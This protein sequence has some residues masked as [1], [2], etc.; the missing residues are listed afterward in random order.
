M[1]KTYPEIVDLAP[2]YIQF[3]FLHAQRR[4]ILKAEEKEDEF[5]FWIS[6]L[7]PDVYK[8][9]LRREE[10]EVLENSSYDEE[11]SEDNFKQLIAEAEKRKQQMQIVNTE[12][13]KP[14]TPIVEPKVENPVTELG[15]KAHPISFRIE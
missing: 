9:I 13:I 12:P 2:H 7:R 10:Q 8:E 5:K 3:H 1:H 14:R 4:Q 15:T 11:M 6:L